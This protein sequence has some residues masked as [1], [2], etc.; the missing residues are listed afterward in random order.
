VDHPINIPLHYKSKPLPSD[1][2]AVRELVGLN[3]KKITESVQ[4]DV[5]VNFYAPWCPWSQRLAPTWQAFGERLQG[6]ASVLVAKFDGTAN[7]VAGLVL[8]AYPT[9]ALYRAV[10]NQIRYYRA[11]V[12]TV[13][14]FLNFLK[15]NA[16]IPFMNPETG[17]LH[18]PPA[19]PQVK[20]HAEDVPELTDDTY[21]EIYAPDKNV[22]V[23][24]YAPW[25]EHSKEMFET[26]EQVAADYKHIDS[27]RVVQMDAHTAK[28][29]R[30]FYFSHD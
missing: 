7:E 26:W 16:A 10:D 25:C 4:H 2:G 23:L 1:Q 24:F 13:D 6:S 15:E 20:D 9:V 11:G 18:V 29:T 3:F 21:E 22:L 30:G 28:K 19:E 27:V 14:A 5:I 12:R 17:E 8:Q